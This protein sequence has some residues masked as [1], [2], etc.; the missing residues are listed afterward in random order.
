MLKYPEDVT[1]LMEC[2]RKYPG[3][4]PKNAER[5]ALYTI[6]NLCKKDVE[7][8]AESLASV[9]NNIKKCVKCGMITD[10]EICEI[11]QSKERTNQLMIVES[12]K[13]VIAFEKT[14]AY[15]GRYHVLN[16][17]I[18]P[19]DGIGIEKLN[20]DNLTCRIEEDKITDVIMAMS[21]TIEGDITAMYLKKM[22]EN[23]KARIYRIGSGLPFG[24]NIEYADEVTLRKSLESKAEM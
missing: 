5:M 9:K 4:G 7:T 6:N 12:I 23:T 21:S 10:R 18:S 8:F 22:L 1:K 3:I 20:C 11:C 13:D 15:N 19:L 17:L 2:F 14:G 24:A 16:G